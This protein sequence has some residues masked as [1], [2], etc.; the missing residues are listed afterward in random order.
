MVLVLLILL[1]LLVPQTIGKYFS[2]QEPLNSEV[3]EKD[4]FCELLGNSTNHLHTEEKASNIFRSNLKGVGK[5]LLP[6]T[7]SLTLFETNVL[8]RSY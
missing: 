7:R 6:F 3:E 4:E 8:F 5:L 2:I 1:N